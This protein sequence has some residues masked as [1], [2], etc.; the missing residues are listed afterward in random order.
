M[1]GILAR[2]DWKSNTMENGELCVVRTLT[3]VLQ[4]LL[5]HSWDFPVF[6]IFQHQ[7][8]YH[9]LVAQLVEEFGW[10]MFSAVV[11]SYHYLIVT[12]MIGVTYHQAA[13]MKMMLESNVTTVIYMYTYVY[14]ILTS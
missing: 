5:V 2:A 9:F 8:H 1:V 4:L 11:M 7:Y 10:I 14:V 12:I 6:G 3:K 13:V